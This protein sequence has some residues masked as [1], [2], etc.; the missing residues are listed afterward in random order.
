ME[1]IIKVFIKSKLSVIKKKYFILLSLIRLHCFINNYIILYIFN[2]IINNNNNQ[3]ASTPSPK[4]QIQCFNKNVFFFFAPLDSFM[5]S[6]QKLQLK[7]QI[8]T[9]G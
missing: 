1:N 8:L 3:A 5:V 2:I 9:N 6:Y 7:V 4:T